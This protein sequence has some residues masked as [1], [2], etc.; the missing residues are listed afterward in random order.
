[1]LG[2]S[3]IEVRGFLRGPRGTTAK[4]VVERLATGK[5]ETIEIVRDAVSQP[6]IGEY[7]MIR[8]GVGLIRM[9]GGFNTTTYAEFARAMRDL[10]SRGM[11]QLIMDLRENGGGLVR[12]ALSVADSFL[13]RGQI[14]F[15]QKGR[16]QGVTEPF[17]ARNASPDQ[18]PIVVLVNRNTASAS[19]H[20]SR[21][22]VL[23]VELGH[24]LSLWLS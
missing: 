21:L 20:P 24:P 13:S 3:F 8:P 23:E 9:N 15:T 1:M 18:S 12:E 2:K 16:R 11:Q 14:I 4:I 7:Y 17:P 19:E 6:S 10:K 5:R 22:E